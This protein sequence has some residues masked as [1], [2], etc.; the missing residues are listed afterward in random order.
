MCTVG[1]YG[2]IIVNPI[3]MYKLIYVTKMVI[4]NEQ[5]TD[6]FYN[7][8]E[9]WKQWAKWTK[10]HKVRYMPSDLIYTDWP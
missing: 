2:K 4:K 9:P 1:M 7:M 6:T 5:N 3:N 8:N 10:P